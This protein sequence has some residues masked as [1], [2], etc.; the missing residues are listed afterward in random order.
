MS[1]YIQNE[2]KRVI[3]NPDNFTIMDS[4]YLSTLF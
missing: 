4:V 3:Y 2:L 1:I